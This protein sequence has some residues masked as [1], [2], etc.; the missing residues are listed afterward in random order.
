MSYINTVILKPTHRCNLN[1]SYCY[2]RYNREKDKTILSKENLVIALRKIAKE[3]DE[4]QAIWHGGELKHHV[5]VKV[6]NMF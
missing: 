1:C 4:F 3:W 6:Y 5:G 2:D